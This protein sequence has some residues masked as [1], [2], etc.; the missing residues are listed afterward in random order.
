MGQR[1]LYCGEIYHTKLSYCEACYN[2]ALSNILRNGVL[3]RWNCGRCW[4]WDYKSNSAVTKAI[5]PPKNY[6]IEA[7]EDPPPSSRTSQRCRDLS[8]IGSTNLWLDEKWCYLCLSQHLKW[9]LEQET[10]GLIYGLNMC[11]EKIGQLG[12]DA[13]KPGSMNEDKILITPYPTLWDSG[14]DIHCF[15]DPCSMAL[16]H[17]W[18]QPFTVFWKIII[19]CH[20]LRQ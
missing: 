12:W 19:N 18:W 2:K 16:S 1:S 15:I 8:E 20:L 9:L 7:S 6:P 4:Q 14:Y 13:N 17:P 3:D 10:N 11:P 5:E